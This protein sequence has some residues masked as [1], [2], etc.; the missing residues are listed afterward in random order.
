MTPFSH[1]YVRSFIHSFTHPSLAS[2][3]PLL[4]SPWGLAPMVDHDKH[5][6][7]HEPL[8]EA[9]MP[10]S[11]LFI[12]SHLHSVE[13]PNA[14][15]QAFPDKKRICLYPKEQAVPGSSVVTQNAPARCRHAQQ[16]WVTRPLQ[17]LLLSACMC[18]HGKWLLFC[19]SLYPQSGLV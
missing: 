17:I 6:S 18:V 15:P 3:L 4:I 16:G 1:S 7:C 9:C 8:Q 5:D 14:S 19:T 10:E 13:T 12:L 2:L 11:T